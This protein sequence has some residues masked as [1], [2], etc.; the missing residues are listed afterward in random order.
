MCQFGISVIIGCLDHEFILVSC[1]NHLGLVCFLDFQVYLVSSFNIEFGFL[2]ESS[3]LLIISLEADSCVKGILEGGRDRV[4]A[5]LLKDIIEF[6][7]GVESVGFLYVAWTSFILLEIGE[8]VAKIGFSTE[9]GWSN[10]FGIEI[11]LE[12]IPNVFLSLLHF[13]LVLVVL[14]VDFTWWVE[15]IVIS[16]SHGHWNKILRHGWAKSLTEF[17]EIEI[18]V[19]I[20]VNELHNGANLFF[21]SL[22]F[23][24]FEALLE[25]IIRHIPIIIF[26]ELFENVIKFN[27]A[28]KYFILNFIY[29]SFDILVVHLLSWNIAC[30]QV[31]VKLD[32]RSIWSL[33][34]SK[35]EWDLIVASLDQSRNVIYISRA[36]LIVVKSWHETFNIFFKDFTFDHVLLNDS[37]HKFSNLIYCDIAVFV[38]W[39]IFFYLGFKNWLI[40]EKL[41]KSSI[42]LNGSRFNLFDHI[43]RNLFLVKND[44]VVF[45]DTPR[46][47]IV[48]CICDSTSHWGT[49]PSWITIIELLLSIVEILYVLNKVS[50]INFTT[51]LIY[52]LWQILAELLLV[53]LN[54][55]WN[56]GSSFENFPDILGIKLVISIWIS[57]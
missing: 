6:K 52:E 36:I 51:T 27:F 46:F 40:W 7:A 26:V 50:I 43:L 15:V 8:G 1:F 11:R 41:V 55:F 39:K 22:N 19:I 23:N 30:V 42:Y 37:K 56:H 14:L 35:F 44:I 31:F 28:V 45:V 38:C 4:F 20:L 34:L 32:W 18:T 53:M 16:I 48:K 25:V 29:Q 21:V 57:G 3:L 47:T 5:W 54:F 2:Q 9:S 13:W 24:G 12:S 17:S 49:R 10:K 33:L